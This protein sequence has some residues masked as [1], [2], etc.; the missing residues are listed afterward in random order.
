MP[1]VAEPP[2]GSLGGALESGSA[3]ERLRHFLE[4]QMTLSHVYQP[5]MIRTIL[6]GG[7]A[8]TRRQIAAAFLTADL[9]Q[10]EYYEQIVKRYPTATLRRRGIVQHHRGVYRLAE[11]M[12]RLNE[13]ECA[14]LMALC[15]A[16]LADYIARRQEAIWRHRAQNFD[17]IPGTIRY[18]VLRRAMGRCEACGITNRERALQVDHIDPRSGGGGNEIENL[19]ALCSTCNAQKLNRDRTDFHAAHDRFNLRVEGCAVC[20]TGLSSA[21]PSNTLALLLPGEEPSRFIVAARRHGS[22]YCDLIQAEVNAIRD[23]EL[24]VAAAGRFNLAHR[25]LN[26]RSAREGHCMIEVVVTAPGGTEAP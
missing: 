18:E 3:Y 8:A 10:L 6:A 23:L 1:D 20:E 21:L 12:A 7:G 2:R 5:L 9:S 24:Q 25:T 14:S 22:S 15:D 4:T 26:D 16:K 17:P 11:N 19:Q 13:W